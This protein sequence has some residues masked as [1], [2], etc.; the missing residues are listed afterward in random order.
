MVKRF[1][2]ILKLSDVPQLKVPRIK[3]DEDD[4]QNVSFSFPRSNTIG[5]R[6]KLLD[7]AVHSSSMRIKWL[8]NVELILLEHIFI[9][10]QQS[11]YSS[12]ISIII[13]NNC[14]ECK[15]YSF[16][17]IKFIV[18]LIELIGIHRN[19]YTNKKDDDFI[20]HILYK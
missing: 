17:R 15:E 13:E 20:Q 14:F 1:L 10:Q 19:R 3:I 16:F 4:K 7:H 2:I 12:L 11:N 18:Y 8:S 5:T 9:Y 6:E